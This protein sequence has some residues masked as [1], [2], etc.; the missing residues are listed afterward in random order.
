VLWSALQYL[1][2]Y[3]LKPYGYDESA[4]P[5]LPAGYT[6]VCTIFHTF[7]EIDNEGTETA[8]EN[9]GADYCDGLATELGRVGLAELG[10]LFRAAWRTH[11]LS[12]AADSVAFEDLITKLHEQIEGDV[13]LDAI[14]RY[15]SGHPQLFEER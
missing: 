3:L 4:I 15:V 7:E 5:P 1:Y 12:A 14:Y 13:T 9:L 8:I 6:T 11:P 10:D 2:G